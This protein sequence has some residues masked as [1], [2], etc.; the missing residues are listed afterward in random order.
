MPDRDPER[1]E[2]AIRRSTP[3]IEGRKKLETEKKQYEDQLQDITS[4]K[5]RLV[6]AITSDTLSEDDVKGEMG[7]LKKKEQ[8]LNGWIFSINSQ[9]TNMPD[10]DKIKKSSNRAFS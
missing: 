5:Q 9:L 6:K 3:D 10:P 7:E 1:I 4:Q 2:Q 8:T